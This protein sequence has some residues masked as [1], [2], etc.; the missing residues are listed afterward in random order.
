M[1]ASPSPSRGPPPKHRKHR[2]WGGRH[3]LGWHPASH[4]RKFAA[5]ADSVKP[6]VSTLPLMLTHRQASD[7]IG[8]CWL[9]FMV[10][11]AV[12]AFTAKRT[13][14]RWSLAAGIGYFLAS[15]VTW[16][17][18]TRSEFL[19]DAHVM[20]HGPLPS[21]VALVACLAGIV[22]T[23]W[24]RIV[25]G[26]N[27]SGSIT[28]KE[29]HELVDRGPYRFVRHPIYTGL[30]LMILGTAIV[31]GTPDALLAFVF[32]FVIHVW[33]LRREEKLMSR[34]FPDSYPGYMS[35]T[36]ALVPFIY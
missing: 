1:R 26:R 4:L 35:R 6:A 11:W 17:L 9:V 29:D 27:W 14:E 16:Y 31:R 20:N 23:V 28:Y 25:L 10:V 33:K 5:A 8:D 3:H 2:L 30:L 7:L 34:Y 12:G 36:K 18:L 15:A 24:A 21:F 13:K 22:I 19:G 32:F